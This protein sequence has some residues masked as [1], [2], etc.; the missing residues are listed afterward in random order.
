MTVSLHLFRV[1][2]QFQWKSNAGSSY[3]RYSAGERLSQGTNQPI[4]STGGERCHQLSQS[5]SQILTKATLSSSKMLLADYTKQVR[6]PAEFSLGSKL[7]SSV[8]HQKAAVLSP[9][10]PDGLIHPTLPSLPLL[11]GSSAAC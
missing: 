11:P 1:E 7:V 4:R 5:V 6:T 10:L 8:C 3:K 9:T 2:G